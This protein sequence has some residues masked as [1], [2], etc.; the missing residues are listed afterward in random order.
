MRCCARASAGIAY[1]TVTD[2]SGGLPLLAPMSRIAGKLSIQFG[3]WALQMAN[4][5]S[6]VLAG[7][8]ARRCRRHAWW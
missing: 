2:A 6:G 3:A 7:R 4:G 8:R 1:E 5:G